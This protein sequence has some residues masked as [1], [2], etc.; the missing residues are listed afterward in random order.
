MKC[1]DCSYNRNGKCKNKTINYKL[2]NEDAESDYYYDEEDYAF[3]DYDAEY[4]LFGDE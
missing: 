3:S 4:G 1:Y 2:E